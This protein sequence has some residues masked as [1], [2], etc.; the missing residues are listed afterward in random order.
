MHAQMDD[1]LVACTVRNVDD[2]RKGGFH[3]SAARFSSFKLRLSSP[4]LEFDAVQ[5]VARCAW[6]RAVYCCAR[7]DIS[8]WHRRGSRAPLQEGEVKA[9]EASTAIGVESAAA[10]P[11]GLEYAS[12]IGVPRA[13]K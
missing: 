9:V 10:F 12:V 4:T 1:G 3:S 2:L 8:P 11:G 5:T 7:A 6:Q 13:T